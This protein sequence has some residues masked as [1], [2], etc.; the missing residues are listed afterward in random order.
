MKKLLTEG[1]SKIVSLYKC[2]ALFAAALSEVSV[3]KLGQ[4]CL[5]S[6]SS[7]AFHMELMEAA[8]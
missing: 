7:E 6:V 5:L 1:L 3:W 8:I 4:Q 2:I